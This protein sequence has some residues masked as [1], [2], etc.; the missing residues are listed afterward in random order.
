M[1]KSTMMAVML[2]FG[3]ASAYALAVQTGTLV[4]EPVNT[5]T[6]SLPVMNYLIELGKEYD[7]FF[8]IEEAWK[9]D[10]STDS[11]T[12]HW[13]PRAAQKTSLTEELEQVRQAVP[14][15]V[16]E[17]DRA[18][19]KII[20]VKDGRLAQQQD[21][22]LEDVIKTITFNGKLP[23][24]VSEINRQ[25]GRVAAPLITFN[26]ETWDY[27]TVVRVKG[28]GLK[29]RDV[30]SDFIPLEGRRS[31]ILWMARTRLGPK[32]VSNIRYP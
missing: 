8:T 27:S 15:F 12:N 24:L 25:G 11:I 26:N 17:I 10:D 32:Q 16:Y 6:R 3:M 7:Y 20:H 18:H 5:Q 1:C 22:A 28:E 29:V 9:D 21:Y 23:D 13:L 4:T 30:L 14:N 19:P 2:M 31:R